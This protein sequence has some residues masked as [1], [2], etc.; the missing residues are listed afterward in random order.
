MNLALN[1]RDAMEQGGQLEL[2]TQ[3]VEVNGADRRGIPAGRWVSLGVEDEGRG[4]DEQTRQRVFEPFFTTKEAGRGTGLGLSTVYGIVTQSGGHIAVESEPERGSRFEVFLPVA[5]A[6]SQVP[7]DA[8]RPSSRRRYTAGTVLLVD[9]MPHVRAPLVR[10]LEEAGFEV[11]EAGSTEEALALPA[12]ALEQLDAVVS[13]VVM[14]G[15]SGIELCRELLALKP[16]LGVVLVSG[17]LRHH[18][19]SRLLHGV[20]FLQKPFTGQRLLDELDHALGG[21]TEA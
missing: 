11:L 9:D 8:P 20:R 12:A 5:D 21:G 15:R 1:A 6:A 4:M 16:G 18:G 17:D 13:D 14:P 2:S 3:L 7:E 10:C 19:T